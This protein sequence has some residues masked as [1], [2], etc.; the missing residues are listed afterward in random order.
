LGL[1]KVETT[2]D[3]LAY[4]SVEQ[5][6]VLMGILLVAW[7]AFATDLQTDRNLVGMMVGKMERTKVVKSVTLWA[8]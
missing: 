3:R 7:K 2:V 8:V 1:R 6:V 5:W 4:W